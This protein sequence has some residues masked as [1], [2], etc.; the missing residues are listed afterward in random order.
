MLIHDLTEAQFADMYAQTIA[1]GLFAARLY[2]PTLPTFSRQE[3]E[4]LIPKSTPF[5]RR[6][7]RQMSMDDEF[8]DRIN[9]IIDSL[10]DIF[11]HC[12]VALIL[13]HH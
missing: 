12:D 6:L 9:H 13:E 7:F 3:A 8:D 2:D 4:K 5:V 10:V 11:L 1:Y